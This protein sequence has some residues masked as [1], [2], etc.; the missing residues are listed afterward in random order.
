MG[1]KKNKIF[2]HKGIIEA[3]TNNEKTKLE[4][5]VICSIQDGFCFS[6]VMDWLNNATNA[7]QYYWP[8]SASSFSMSDE[9]YEYYQE[10]AVL[11]YQYQENNPTPADTE[12]NQVEM[13]LDET[14]QRTI[15]VSILDKLYDAHEKYIKKNQ[16]LLNMRKSGEC[17][18]TESVLDGAEVDT[19]KK[20]LVLQTFENIKPEQDTNS[21]VLFNM[22]LYKKSDKRVSR[23]SIGVCTATKNEAIYYKVLD[24]TIGVYRADS[25][26]D[27]AEC[28]YKKCFEKYNDKGYIVLGYQYSVMQ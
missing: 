26:T 23:H 16:L 19:E 15:R 4:D 3:L 7:E 12:V 2:A 25:I 22:I 8:I 18:F 14:T 10:L 21:K 20:A 13:Y 1:Y 11:F 24:P 17:F 28:V 27:I 6:I 9:Q 5:K